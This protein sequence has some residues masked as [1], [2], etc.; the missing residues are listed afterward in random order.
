MPAEK[1][2]LLPDIGAGLAAGAVVLP[3]AIAFGVALWAPF[4][5]DPG[6]A[7]LAGLIGATALS[8]CTSLIGGARG[9]IYSPTGPALVLLSGALAELVAGGVNPADLPTA[10]AAIL[11]G[12]GIIQFLIGVTGAG[13]LVKFLPYPVV[14]GFMTG[15]AI[16]MGLSQLKPLLGPGLSGVRDERA[17]VPLLVAAATFLIVE[18]SPLLFRHMPATLAG[19]FGGTLLFHLLIRTGP[20]PQGWVVGPLPPITSVQLGLNLS[21]LAQLPWALVAGSAAAMALLGSIN[22][23]LVTVTAD[24]IT[25]LRSSTR[26]TLAGLGAGQVLTGLTGGVGGSATT[27]ATLVA[28]RAG[29]RSQVGLVC[30][31]TFLLIMV[32]FSPAGNWL[33]IGVLSGI[34]LNVAAHT[35]DRDVIA[36]L[37]DRRMRVDAGIAILVAVVTVAYDLMWAVALGVVIAFLSFMRAQVVAPVIHQRSTAKERRSMRART[38]T[39]RA[40]VEAHGERIVLYELRGDLFFATADQLFRELEKD[41]ERRAI[42]ILHLRRVLQIDL[43]ALR[44]LTQI[45][46]RLHENGGELLFC[47]VHELAGADRSMEHQLARMSSAP[48]LGVQTFEGSDEALEYA[49]DRLLVECRLPPSQSHEAVP[50]EANEFCHGVPPEKAAALREVLQPRTIAAGGTLFAAGDFGDSLMIVLQG[51]IEI[52]L[53]TPDGYSKRLARYGPGTFFGEIALLT[54][55]PRTASAIARTDS[56]LLVLDRPGFERLIASNPETAVASLLALGQAQAHEL[57]SSTSEILRLIEW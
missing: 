12:A 41:L 6:A 20:H 53:L 57:R 34:V 49:E 48:I 16:Q 29:G 25:G 21:T 32:C 19:L 45:A 14:V 5:F 28:V 55:G 44:I 52:R 51:D 9:A 33:P 38:R 37:R 4:P 35:I 40:A 30:A 27:G 10:L 42:V 26:R 17:W 8:L 39:Q 50:L 43:T 47:N 23:L 2:S 56:Q 7:A 18:Y 31:V 15:A 13:H 36:W 22:T 46:H 24:S 54:P 11:I 3:Q 1:S